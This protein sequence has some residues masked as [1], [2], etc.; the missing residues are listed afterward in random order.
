MKSEDLNN[1]F[2]NDDIER[3]KEEAEERWRDT[4]A[5]KQ[6]VERTKSWTEKDYQTVQAEH[7]RIARELVANMDKRIE[8]PEVQALIKEHWNQINK[9]YD[10]TPEIYLGLAE[11][12]T[13]DQRFADFYRKYDETLPEFLS[14]AMKWFVRTIG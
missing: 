4:D 2:E 3:Y 14:E 10:C 9:F 6:S 7:D 11:I 1:S 5:Y 8:S 12:Y 13:T